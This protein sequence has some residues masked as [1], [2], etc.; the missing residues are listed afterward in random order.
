MR[1]A[2]EETAAKSV[3][4]RVS[5]TVE[6]ELFERKLAMYKDVEVKAANRARIAAERKLEDVRAQRDNW[7]YQANKYRL[8]VIELKSKPK[9]VINDRT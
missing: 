9:G 1:R 4:A 2:V 5:A 8:A 6:S 3:A 7:R